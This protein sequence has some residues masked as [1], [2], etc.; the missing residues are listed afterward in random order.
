MVRTAAM[1][2]VTEADLKMH[3]LEL[4]IFELSDACDEMDRLKRSM[5]SRVRDCIREERNSEALSLLATIQY[6]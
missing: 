1:T 2:E 4:N 6:A 5:E 3:E